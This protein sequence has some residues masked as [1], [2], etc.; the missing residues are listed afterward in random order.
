MAAEH[1]LAA[2]VARGPV[3]VVGEDPTPEATAGP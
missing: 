3:H 1:L 2:R